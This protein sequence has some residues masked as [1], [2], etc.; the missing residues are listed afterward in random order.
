[1]IVTTGSYIVI[2]FSVNTSFREQLYS[3]L[4][5]MSKLCGGTGDVKEVNDEVQKIC[6][7]VCSLFSLALRDFRLFFHKLVLSRNKKRTPFD[8][9]SLFFCLLQD[10]QDN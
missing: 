7:Q 2:S 1:M 4:I 5:K 3:F 8:S 10:N 9:W 6:D